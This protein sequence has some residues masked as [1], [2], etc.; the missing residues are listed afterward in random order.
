MHDLQRWIA[1]G[2]DDVVV[3]FAPQIA[4]KIP[5]RMVRFRRDV[6]ALFSFIM[7]SAILHQAQRK[8]DTDGRVVATV[9]DYAVAYPIFSRVLA[10][11]CGQGVTD[12]VRAVVDLIAARAGPIA[13][14]ATGGRFA[15]TEPAGASAEVELSSEQIGTLTGIGKSAAYRAVKAAIDQGFLVNNE[16]RRGKPYR[17]VVRQRIDEADT[18]LLP[19]PDTLASDGATP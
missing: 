13:T 15:R 18:A 5:P 11:T 7:A 3:P 9:A 6:G 19:H 12:N 14:K 1:L 10:Q 17:L 8:R 4:A 16:T 2:P